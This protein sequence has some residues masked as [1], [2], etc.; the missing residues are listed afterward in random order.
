LVDL[1]CRHGEFLRVGG[2]EASR[3]EEIVPGKDYPVA[4]MPH[5]TVQ[6]HADHASQIAPLRKLMGR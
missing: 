6:Q 1:D 3:L 5:G 2:L 4:V